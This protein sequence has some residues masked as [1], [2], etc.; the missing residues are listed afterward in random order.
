LSKPSDRT[1]QAPVD[2]RDNIVRAQSFVE[3]ATFQHFAADKL[4]LYAVTRCLEIVSEASRRV[5][6]E[7]QARYPAIP[8]LLM[9]RAGNIYRHEYRSVDPELIWRTV[10][11]ALPTLF[12]IVEAEL[13]TEP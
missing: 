13:A 9:A 4:R 11:E 2:S 5:G 10:T 8:W 1:R 6:A 7:F 3:A 12:L